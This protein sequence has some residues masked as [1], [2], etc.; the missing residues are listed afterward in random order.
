MTTPLVRWK[1]VGSLLVFGALFA[2][3]WWLLAD[4]ATRRAVEYAG[5]EIVGARVDLRAADLRLAEGAVRLSGLAVTNP[6]EPMRNLFE[7]D[8]IVASMRALPLLEK[9]VIVDTVA[10]RG[11]RFGTE[12]R[13][14]GALPRPSPTSGRLVREVSG[15]ARGVRIPSLSL[16]GLTGLVDVAAISPDSLRTIALARGLVGRADSLEDT[17][18]ADLA[19]LN[20]G[21][22]LDSA[23]AMIQR[24]REAEPVRLGLAGV[25]SLADGGR[26]QLMSLDEHRR[27]LG[28]VDDR[29]AASAADLRSHVQGL[30]DA[31]AADVVWAR[32]L[33]KLPSVD[34]PDVSPALFGEMALARV[35]PF[36]YWLRVAEQYL[37]P[38]LDPRRRAG[39]DRARAAGVTVTFP[40][41][42]ALPAFLLAF[43]AADLELGGR[44]ATAGRYAARLTGLT[45]E[46]ALYGRPLI[47]AAE[48]SEGVA[49]PRQAALRAVLNHVATPVRDSVTAVLQGL[50]LAP[51]PLPALG[52]RLG[53]N[54]VAL[55]VSLVRTGDSLNARLVWRT[56]NAAWTREGGAADPGAGGAVGSR[57]WA[58]GLLW[59]TASSLRSVEIETR[60][61]GSVNSPALAIRSNVGR[62]VAAAL[63]RELG[64]QVARAE[65]RVRAEV[66][67]LVEAR[68]TE[69][70]QRTETVQGRAR[71][72]IAAQRRQLDEVRGTLEAEVR[73]LTTRLPIRIP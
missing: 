19:A 16:E 57:A 39:P 42:E 30:A 67:R 15:W 28:D 56:D 24:L 8:E 32:G 29:V 50:S 69:A 20:P 37:P 4:R 49:G 23:R 73:N 17:W 9:K 65:Q 27:R 7:A 70:R 53:L 5:T 34:S 44:G 63:R 36:L 22:R 62:E 68:V 52:A 48:R 61:S 33:L 60:L 12:R 18:R 14:S 55:Q 51:V 59:R 46:P 11:L 25:R 26:A 43:A 64:A 2:L 35:Q 10:V 38:G 40:R 1:A 31:R 13:E 21:P 72:A 54:D 71:E 3:G 41:R 66:D 58:E 6:N 45:S 47:L